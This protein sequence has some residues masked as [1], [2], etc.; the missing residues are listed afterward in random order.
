[1]LSIVIDLHS[2]SHFG[3]FF[4]QSPYLSLSILSTWLNGN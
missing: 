1:L 4:V 2:L 3:I